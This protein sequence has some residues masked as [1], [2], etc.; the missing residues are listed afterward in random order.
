MFCTGA[1]PALPGIS[2]RFSRPCRPFSRQV[3]TNS[4]QFSPAAT[5]TRP[6]SRSISTPRLRISRTMPGKSPANSTLLPPPS[7][8]SG[9]PRLS[10]SSRACSRSPVSR[11]S[12]R[13]PARAA[14]PKVL[15]GVR[16]ASKV[17]FMVPAGRLPLRRRANSPPAK[18]EWR[19]AARGF[20][21]K[22]RH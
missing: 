19:E 8:N 14:T 18:G 7:S 4:C 13:Q 6:L 12:A 20:Q 11:I 9:I 5:R 2:A 3:F 21:S 10:A 15:C 22:P 17:G 1:A 16:S